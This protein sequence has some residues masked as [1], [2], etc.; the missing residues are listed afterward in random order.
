MLFTLL[1]MACT[2]PSA[3]EIIKSKPPEQILSCKNF[4]ECKPE[5]EGEDKLSDREIAICL[6]D[7]FY[8]WKDCN[9]K[10]QKVRQF[11]NN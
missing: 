6:L 11:I 7:I 5:I 2:T 4:P 8:A 10:L 1:L 3:P 9:E